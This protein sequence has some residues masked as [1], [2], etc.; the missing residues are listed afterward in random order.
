VASLLLLV[1]FFEIKKKNPR[2]KIQN[3]KQ[4]IPEKMITAR[5]AQQQGLARSTPQSALL[6]H[7]TCALPPVAVADCAPPFGFGRM[8]EPEPRTAKESAKEA[9]AIAIR[10]GEA[11]RGEGG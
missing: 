11:C 4:Q 7:V 6:G 8:K 9:V 10:P 3:Q 1:F 2:S 5:L